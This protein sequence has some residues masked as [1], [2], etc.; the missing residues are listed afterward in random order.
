MLK[1]RLMEKR[2][3]LCLQSDVDALI[4]KIAGI[5]LPALRSMP[6]CAHPGGFVT[7]RKI[8]ACVFQVR[9]QLAAIAA[10]MA[11]AADEPPLDQ[12]S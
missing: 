7:R 11:D 3:Q 6:A 1:L 5:T 10:E 2:G 9:K 12:Q 8:E 4:D